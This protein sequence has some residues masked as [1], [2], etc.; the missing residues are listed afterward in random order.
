MNRIPEA[1]RSL[2][3]RP[4]PHPGSCGER[5]SPPCG[6]RAL[7]PY[8]AAETLRNGDTLCH[9]CSTRYRPHELRLAACCGRRTA[10]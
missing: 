9:L 10:A 6:S 8:R 7:A 4:I 3:V 2:S 1:D 5:V